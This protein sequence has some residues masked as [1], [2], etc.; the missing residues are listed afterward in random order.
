VIAVTNDI[1]GN[2]EESY[3]YDVYGAATI[4]NPIGTTIS[5]SA[6][7]NRFLF[8]GREWIPAVSLYDYRNRY[9]TT[10]LGRFLQ[11]DPIRLNAR[12]V[13]LYRY[14]FNNPPNRSDP[15]GKVA[16][17]LA[18]LDISIT[19]DHLKYGKA[20]HY[21]LGIGGSSKDLTTSGDIDSKCDYGLY[22]RVDSDPKDPKYMA[23]HEGPIALAG[24]DTIKGRKY[25]TVS[26]RSGAPD[27]KGTRLWNTVLNV[28]S[29]AKTPVNEIQVNVEAGDWKVGGVVDVVIHR[30]FLNDTP[31]TRTISIK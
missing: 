31:W 9:Y 20:A 16:G 28:G 23:A 18:G 30:E 8:T 6:I 25:P 24:V 5:T 17:L 3:S 7:G 4:K 12:D 2:V 11:T 22:V 21:F 13:N 29:G 1:T 27:V 14:V 10:Q 19:T 26:D 15:F